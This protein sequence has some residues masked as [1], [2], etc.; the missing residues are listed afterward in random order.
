MPIT[1]PG[2]NDVEI[3]ITI[4]DFVKNKMYIKS[5]QISNSER[6]QVAKG[7]FIASETLT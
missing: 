4:D 6:L 2:A 7:S 3:K 5:G 1:N